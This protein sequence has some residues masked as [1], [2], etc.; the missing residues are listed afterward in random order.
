MRIENIMEKNIMVNENTI[1]QCSV[2]LTRNCNLRCNFCY[3]KDAGYCENEIVSFENLK[4][5][6]SVKKNILQRLKPV[7]TVYLT[8]NK[9]LRYEKNRGNSASLHG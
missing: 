3:V 5:I 1:N 2:V 4:K 9:D 8:K 7:K 6:K